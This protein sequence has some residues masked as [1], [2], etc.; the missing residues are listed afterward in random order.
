ML[1]Q[2]S[3]EMFLRSRLAPLAKADIVVTDYPADTQKTLLIVGNHKKSGL[4]TPFSKAKL[5]N[6]LEKMYE[7]KQLE[8]LAKEGANEFEDEINAVMTEFSKK[9]KKIFA[10]R[11]Y[12]TLKQ[13]QN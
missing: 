7:E 6:V 2:K 1:L 11:L 5:L 10:R 9:I 4:K 13:N 12:D 8:L 3:I